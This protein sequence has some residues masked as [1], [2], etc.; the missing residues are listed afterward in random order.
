MFI[1][2]KNVPVVNSRVKMLNDLKKMARNCFTMVSCT[3]MFR[4][5]HIKSR[6]KNGSVRKTVNVALKKDGHQWLLKRG[7]IEF[8]YYADAIHSGLTPPG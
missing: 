5:E 1:L 7:Y 2:P 4:K 3:I 8:K 6:L